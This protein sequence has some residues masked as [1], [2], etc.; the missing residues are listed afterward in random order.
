MY[1]LSDKGLKVHSGEIG[2]ENTLPGRLGPKDTL[3]R[4][5][6]G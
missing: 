6:Y 4:K 3:I 5:G 1:Y 2:L